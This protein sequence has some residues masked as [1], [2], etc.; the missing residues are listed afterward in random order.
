MDITATDEWAALVDHHREVGA[1]TLRELFAEDAGRGQRLTG[2][3]G[4]LYVDWS[5][6]R[7]TDQTV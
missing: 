5:K 4:D 2:T 6:H 7:V 1:R 3:A